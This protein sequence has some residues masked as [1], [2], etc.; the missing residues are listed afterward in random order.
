MPTYEYE[1]RACQHRFEKFQSMSEDPVRVCPA[2][3]GSV[4]R[5]IGGGMGIIFKGPGFYVTDSKSASASAALTAAK[6]EG[7]SEAGAESAAPA[8]AS[9]SA[10]A[11]AAPAATSKASEPQSSA[12][13]KES[14]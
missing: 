3:G 11:A 2:C 8:A 7:G 6:K 14:A 1:C 10:S 4:R 5:V 12:A 13:S 9:A